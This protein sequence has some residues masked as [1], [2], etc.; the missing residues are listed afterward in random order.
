MLFFLPANADIDECT[1]ENPCGE[2]AKCFNTHGSYRCV[3]NSSSSH[4]SG[5]EEHGEGEDKDMLF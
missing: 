3:W 4:S 5:E 1:G 2:N